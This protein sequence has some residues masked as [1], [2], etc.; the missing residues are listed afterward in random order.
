MPEDYVAE[1][2]VRLSFYKR[3]ASA[4]DES[5]GGRS[6]REME[7]RFGPPPTEAQ[8]LV[9][10]MRLKT[11]LRRLMVLGCEASAK[12]VTLHLRDDTPLDPAEDR[13]SGGQEEERLSHF[14]PTAG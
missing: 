3:L 6:G 2:G 8:R 4:S 12:S 9:E 1:V 11:E 10:L 5:R 13:R 14:S 7:D